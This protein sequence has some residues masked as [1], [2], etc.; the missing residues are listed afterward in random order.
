MADIPYK[1]AT[2]KG[3]ICFMGTS[4]KV[5]A[6]AL[7]VLLDD[8]DTE[9][10]FEAKLPA[11]VI[12]TQGPEALERIKDDGT[13][14]ALTEFDPQDAHP[15]L[16]GGEWGILESFDFVILPDSM[17]QSCPDW[18]NEQVDIALYFAANDAGNVAARDVRKLELRATKS[19]A[20]IVCL[21]DPEGIDLDIEDRD[22]AA[23]T[24][25]GREHSVDFNAENS[26]HSML[27]MIGAAIDAA[28]PEL[29]AN[30][31]TT[32]DDWSPAV[33]A[34]DDVSEGRALDS[35]EDCKQLADD[36]IARLND[37]PQLSPRRKGAS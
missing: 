13:R 11:P 10:F 15:I 2:E 18:L 20:I 28:Y 31:T 19:G 24:R 5:L 32:A 1:V 23:G 34:W 3:C 22:L 17:V 37:A 16:I 29:G 4:Q 7:G 27:S 9:S 25:F 35:V 6:Q 33:E 36:L 26:M 8:K 21:D 14:S 12:L 30:R